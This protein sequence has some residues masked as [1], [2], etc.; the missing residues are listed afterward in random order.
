MCIRDRYGCGS[1]K[2]EGEQAKEIEGDA[3]IEAEL[4]EEAEQKGVGLEVDG[5]GVVTGIGIGVE[6]MEA[7]IEVGSA[8]SVIRGEIV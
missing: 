7:A 5:R 2:K 6:E 1:G 3:G 4:L 8:L